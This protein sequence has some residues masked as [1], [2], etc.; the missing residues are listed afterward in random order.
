[1]E[2]CVSVCV[3]LFSEAAVEGIG[4]GCVSPARL[5]CGEGSAVARVR[6]RVLQMS[7]SEEDR[8]RGRGCVEGVEGRGEEPGTGPG[9]GAPE[10]GGGC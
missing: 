10:A 5:R 3:F 2:V 9:K 6:V 7:L 1:M 8:A 4:V